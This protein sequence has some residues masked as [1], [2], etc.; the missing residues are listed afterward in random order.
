MSASG[1]TPLGYHHACLRCPLGLLPPFCASVPSTHHFRVRCASD[2]FHSSFPYAWLR[3]RLRNPLLWSL[4]LWAPSRLIRTPA[5]ILFPTARVRI[6]SFFP[7][8]PRRA[9]P[10][11]GP[12]SESEPPALLWRSTDLA[13]TALADVPRV[14]PQKQTDAGVRDRGCS[15]T[16]H[17]PWLSVFP[18][19]CGSD[20]GRQERVQR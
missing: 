19:T 12:D 11:H 13:E 17:L 18:P 15:R 1:D 4:V 2:D 5:G 8:P 7:L 16:R 3:Q 10:A 6:T 20:G 9:L 14:G